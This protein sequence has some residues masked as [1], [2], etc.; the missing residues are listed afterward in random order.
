MKHIIKTTL[1]LLC[2][3]LPTLYAC[4]QP[5]AG[6]VPGPGSIPPPPPGRTDAPPPPAAPAPSPG[7]PIQ[8]L[9]TIR[10]T[11]DTYTS[12]DS[13]HYDG[14]TLHYNG[15]PSYVRFAPHMAAQL[16]A[17][18]KPGASISIQGFYETTPE[19]LNAIHLVNA[20][21]GASNIFDNPP[22]PPATPAVENIEP[23]NGAITGLRRDREGTPTG[24]VLS[25]NRIL[26]L[27]PG[28]YDQL[29]AYLKPGASIT[30]SASRR[31]PPPGVVPVQ[32]TQTIHPQTLTIDGQTYM[33]R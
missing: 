2:I 28:V 16:M 13:N 32:N 26:E 23:F 10:G 11:I 25:G 12:S 4:S 9:V 1:V 33:V 7:H 14:L 8:Q 17:A 21:A 27:A 19:G 22:A 24:V 29:Q 30:G 3:A 18:A 6:P 20:T 5:P 15:Q 31:L